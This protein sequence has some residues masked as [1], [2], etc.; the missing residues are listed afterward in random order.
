MYRGLGIENVSELAMR[1]VQDRSVASMEMTMGHL[2]ERVLEGLGPRKLS[3][4]EKTQSGFRGI[5]FVQDT[6]AEHRLINLKAGLPTS[7]SK[8]NHHSVADHIVEKDCSQDPNS[9]SYHPESQAIPSWLNVN[10]SCWP[11]SYGKIS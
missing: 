1:L 2:Y 8:D 7:N 4:K 6:A 9:P 11:S 10:G 5:D 3:N